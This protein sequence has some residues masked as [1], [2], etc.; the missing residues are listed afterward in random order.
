MDEVELGQVS[1]LLQVLRYSP[2]S[3]VPP[4]LH[5]HLRLH[6]AVTRTGG[7]QGNFRKQSS[8]E[9]RGSLNRRVLLFSFFLLHLYTAFQVKYRLIAQRLSICV[10]TVNTAAESGIGPL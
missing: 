7:S 6:V 8:F 3:I 10:S 5:S 4:K 9:N 1:F 2:V